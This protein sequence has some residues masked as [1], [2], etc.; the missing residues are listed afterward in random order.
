MGCEDKY[1]RDAKQKEKN[2]RELDKL[3]KSVGLELFSFEDNLILFV[4][5]LKK[6]P[7]EVRVKPE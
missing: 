4:I 1:N 7:V 6:L 5:S 3:G 2:H